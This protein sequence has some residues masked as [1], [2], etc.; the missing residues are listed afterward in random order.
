M[1]HL[2]ETMFYVGQEPWHGLGTKLSQPPTAREAIIQAGLDWEIAT[3]PIYLN[4]PITSALEVPG[5]PITQV[6]GYD[7]NRFEVAPE[8]LAVRRLSD[9]KVLGITG[10]RWTPVQSRDAFGIFDPLVQQGLATFHTAGSLDGGKL[11]WIL[12]QIGNEQTIIGAD[13]TAHFLLLNMGHNGW[14]GIN[15][16]PT[17]VRV[18]CA[19]TNGMA[20]ARAKAGK[21]MRTFNH[22]AGVIQ[23]LEDAAD[24]LAPYLVS[25][26]ATCDAFRIMAQADLDAEAVDRVIRH[27]FP[28]PVREDG[29]PA[30][31]NHI[32]KVRA[33]ILGRFEGGLIGHDLLPA[34]KRRTA[35]TLYNAITEFVDHTRGRS[36]NAR[37]SSAWFGDGAAI[38]ETA[39]KALI[40]A[41]A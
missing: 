1:A 3:Q 24:F 26:E 8:W 2:V 13:T 28:D 27:C 14:R 31:T 36:E 23:R 9:G 21:L 33:D 30:R 41:A 17:E 4:A 15:M 11:I 22:T 25:F 7:E 29:T 34:D 35:W 19:N 32:E 39:R 37:L 40:L 20:E 6:T 5:G 38:K 18:V 12:C 10:P 16:M